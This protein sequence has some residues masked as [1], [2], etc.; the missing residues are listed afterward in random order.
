MDRVRENQFTRS[1]AYI[2][3]GSGHDAGNPE[4]CANPPSVPADQRQPES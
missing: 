3:I 2:S 1:E 4:V